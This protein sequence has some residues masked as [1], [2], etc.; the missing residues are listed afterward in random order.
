MH[1][2]VWALTV[3]LGLP[4]LYILSVP[5]VCYYA[6]Q[7]GQ[8]RHVPPPWLRRYA[9]P[10]NWLCAHTPLREPLYA[11]LEWWVPYFPLDH[12]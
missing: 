2:K 6:V 11:Y 8:Y 3:L 12:P 10:Y 1:A 7:S 5:P 4:L 9:Y